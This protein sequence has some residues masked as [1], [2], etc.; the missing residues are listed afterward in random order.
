MSTWA[1]DDGAKRLLIWF[2]KISE[3][4][5]KPANVKWMLKKLNF[6][7]PCSTGDIPES[8]ASQRTFHEPAASITWEPARKAGFQTPLQAYWLGT[9]I[10]PRSLSYLCAHW[11][12]EGCHWRSNEHNTGRLWKALQVAQL[13]QA[14]SLG[15]LRHTAPEIEKTGVSSPADRVNVMSSRELL[16]DSTWDCMKYYVK[17]EEIN[18]QNLL[19]P[20]Y[21]TRNSL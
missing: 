11:S 6:L 2:Y 14:W 1:S 9:C 17:R 7:P 20:F 13:P 4:C 15:L 19:L 12:W 18:S 8:L 3:L 21:E 10:W 5:W 16:Y